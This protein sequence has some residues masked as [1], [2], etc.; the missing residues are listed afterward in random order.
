MSAKPLHQQIANL[1]IDIEAQESISWILFSL[2]GYADILAAENRR[3]R[4]LEIL[5]LCKFHP[6]TLSLS[7]MI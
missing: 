2:V 5:G 6:G 7:W 4:A 3:D 1:K